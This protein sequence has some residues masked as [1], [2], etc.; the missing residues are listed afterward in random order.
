[1]LLLPNW[2]LETPLILMP[3]LSAN[4]AERVVLSA[5]LFSKVCG[6]KVSGKV[7]L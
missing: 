3:F 2:K 7:L 5:S 1:M 4:I 6:R